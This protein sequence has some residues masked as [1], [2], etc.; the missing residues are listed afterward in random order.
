[1][2]N[3][4][5]EELVN[6]GVT[7]MQV[8]NYEKAKEAFEKAIDLDKHNKK[9][10]MHLGNALANLDSLE[11]AKAAFEKVLLIDPNEGEAYFNIGNIYVLQD[12]LYKCVENY[13]KAEENGFTQIE[14]YSNLAGIFREL[15]DTTQ[16][17]RNLNKAIKVSPLS[18]EVRI[19]KAHIY[20]NEGRYNEA[21]ETLE[22]LQ[23]IIP[24]AFEAYDLQTQIYCG[25]K[26]YD[27]ALE[28]IR[29]GVERFENDVVLKWI[30][31]KVLVEKQDYSEAKKVIYEIRTMDGYSTVE[32]EV[33]FQ[34]AIIFSNENNIDGAIES[35][36]NV[37]KSEGEAVD[38]Q[39]RYLLM[40]L[41]L[42]KKDFDKSLENALKLESTHS[43]TLF[44]ISGIYYVAHILK[45]KGKTEEAMSRFKNASVHLRKLSIKIPTFYE[46]YLYR[47]LCHK[48]LGEY[49]KALELAEYIENLY[50]NKSDAYAMRYAVYTDMGM[51]DEAEAQKQ[52]A[53]ELNPDL[54][55]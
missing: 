9:A 29:G 14:L 50:P 17:I 13:N 54:I 51:T 10:Y 12:E 28:I 43:D 11:E 2:D 18:G 47:L 48:E 52:K 25:L 19:E 44:N 32:R 6:Q 33:A 37:L 22:E 20:L 42:G 16:A 46:I 27:K 26:Q 39:I 1:M 8:Q 55:I 41:Y 15:G 45:Q 53:K 3:E 7:L 23:K 24:D 38:E 40:N 4:R 36:E 30:L 35:L 34:E 21:L 49:E 5:Y 31:I